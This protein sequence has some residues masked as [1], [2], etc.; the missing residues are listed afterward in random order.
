MCQPLGTRNLTVPMNLPRETGLAMLL[1]SLTAG[2]FAAEP[3]IAPATH[4]RLDQTARI[5]GHVTHVLGAPRM[6]TAENGPALF[7]NGASDGLLVPVNPLA[8][9]PQFTVEVLFRPEEGGLAEQRFVH[10]QDT[11]AWRVMIE[12]R[13]NG[14]GGWWLDTFLGNGRINQPLIDPRR[15]H[16]TGQ[17]Y[18]VALTYDGKRMTHY[19]NGQKELEAEVAFGPMTAGQSSL[20]VRQ[21]QVFWFKG[22]IRELRFHPAALTPAQLQRPEENQAPRL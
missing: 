2:L 8:G 17:W 15:V 20:G 5:G 9:W 6:V 3:P 22:G 13:L 14:A 1:L 7:F 12:T 16:P 19:V 18:W 11:A 4:W 21:N 10:L